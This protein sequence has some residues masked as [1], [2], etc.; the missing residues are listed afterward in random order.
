MITIVPLL[1]LV[2]VKI[3]ALTLNIQIDTNY[4]KNILQILRLYIGINVHLT[5]SFFIQMKDE[6]SKTELFELAVI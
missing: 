4:S 2:L 3:T 6:N 1:K 5:N